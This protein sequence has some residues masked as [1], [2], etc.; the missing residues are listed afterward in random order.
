MSFPVW[1]IVLGAIAWAVS[2]VLRA[3][4]V[5][6][7]DARNPFRLTVSVLGYAGIIAAIYGVIVLS[8]QGV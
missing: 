8:I 4:F 2:Y 1:C 6:A 5:D 7:S 3:N